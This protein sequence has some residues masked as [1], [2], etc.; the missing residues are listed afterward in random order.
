MRETQPL[1]RKGRDYIEVKTTKNIKLVLNIVDNL[2]AGKRF[3]E[4][5][6]AKQMYLLDCQARLETMQLGFFEERD[7]IF[8]KNTIDSLLDVLMAASCEIN[9]YI[10]KED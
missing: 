5:D 1:E 7:L 4:L 10:P 2:I 3:G 6:S 9:K 8:L